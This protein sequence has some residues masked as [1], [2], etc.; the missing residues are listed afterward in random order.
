[1]ILKT[2]ISLQL[3]VTAWTATVP[4]T[5]VPGIFNFT[6][7]IDM[8]INI[9]S[10]ASPS[11][12]MSGSRSEQAC[13]LT[14][15]AECFSTSAPR[16]YTTVIHIYRQ[17]T[18]MS[19]C[20]V[21]DDFER[22]T[23]PYKSKCT[24]SDTI[25]FDIF[26]G[27]IQYLCT[28]QGYNDYLSFVPC[29]SNA[30]VTSEIN[31]CVANFPSPLRLDDL[32][33]LPDNYTSCVMQ[34][35]SGYCDGTSTN[36]LRQ[37]LRTILFPL[38]IATCQNRS[39]AADNAASSVMV[40]DSS[41]TVTA[42][43]DIQP[44]LLLESASVLEPVDA[45]VETYAPDVAELTKFQIYEE[46]SSSTYPIRLDESVTVAPQLLQE[47]SETLAPQMLQ[48]ESVTIAPQILQ[49]ESVTIAPQI[50]LD[51]SVSIAPQIL[52]KESVTVPP[53]IPQEE[54]VTTAPQILLDES[55][56]IAPQ[57][58]LDESV[59]IASQTMQEES[60][61]RESQLPSQDGTTITSNVTTPLTYE[62]STAELDTQARQ[63]NSSTLV[64]GIV[65]SKMSSEGSSKVVLGIYPSSLEISTTM[66]YITPH[67]SIRD[68][69]VR[70]TDVSTLFESTEAVTGDVTE[71]LAKGY[72]IQPTIAEMRHRSSGEHET[73]T[74]TT[75]G[76]K[77]GVLSTIVT[78]SAT[79]RLSSQELPT[80]V[81][82]DSATTTLS[83]QELP[84]NVQADSVTATS[85]LESSTDAG[86]AASREFSTAAFD[87]ANT[88]TSS[89]QEFSKPTT[90]ILKLTFSR[91][92][93]LTTE[94]DK[95]SPKS[96]DGLSATI[97]GVT[98]VQELLG[99]FST[100]PLEVRAVQESQ[101]STAA[102]SQGS[103]EI[104]SA[105]PPLV[106][107]IEASSGDFSITPIKAT[108]VQTSTEELSTVPLEIPTVV[109]V[110][111][112]EFSTA[113]VGVT[114]SQMSSENLLTELPYVITP[115]ELHDGFSTVPLHFSTSQVLSEEPPTTVVNG[116][117]LSLAVEDVTLSA[118]VPHATAIQSTL[119]VVS[120]PNSGTFGISPASLSTSALEIHV[121]EISPEQFLTVAPE[122][123]TTKMSVAEIQTQAADETVTE[124]L[125]S[126][127]TTASPDIERLRYSSREFVTES[128]TV[129]ATQIPSG[130]FSTV[131]P[132]IGPPKVV[133]L[134]RRSSTVAAD[135]PSDGLPNFAPGTSV[136]LISAEILPTI[137][138][139]VTTVEASTTATL[140]I[141]TD[142]SS[143]TTET[144][145]VSL[146]STT[147]KAETPIINLYVPSTSTEIK[148]NSN[149][150]TTISSTKVS[151]TGQELSTGI[152]AEVTT[153][154]QEYTSSADAV[155][156][157][158]VD[159]TTIHPS[160]WAL[161][162]TAIQNSSTE[163]A[164]LLEGFS[165]VARSIATSSISLEA[166][167]IASQQ[168]QITPTS[169]DV[170]S[171]A[172]VDVKIIQTSPQETTT[173]ASVT[174]AITTTSAAGSIAT[175]STPLKAPIATQL[176]ISPTS[177]DVMSTAAADATITQTFSQE[178]TTTA[179]VA[180]APTTTASSRSTTPR[181]FQT[182]PL[183]CYDCHSGAPG[184]WQNVNC[185]PNG[186]IQSWAATPNLCHG[187]CVS[188]VTKYPAGDVFRACSK[189]YYFPTAPPRDGCITHNQDL[190]CFCST[191]FCNT[192]D[193]VKEQQD[194]VKGTST[195]V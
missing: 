84:K 37:A 103:F 122:I 156:A 143:S 14:E 99:E 49:E 44:S 107:P 30:E 140:S 43:L 12:N 3:F 20:G 86:K 102:S 159:G 137:A 93:L 29:I 168:L 147:N 142:V 16:F 141:A 148:T 59:T 15:I 61:I 75:D 41:A 158:V 39:S 178:T 47:E 183:N 89:Q 46:G 28:E 153:L 10:P 9:S 173:T 164:A 6:S 55:V 13:Q 144:P 23:V 154:T 27:L 180:T 157:I 123:K 52:Q 191:D 32:C 4:T 96:V 31:T 185:P 51:E 135:I 116:V 2:C 92:K 114:T 186:L 63:Q 45:S 163:H 117:A 189:N 127:F 161:A 133:S 155:S 119:G 136:T 174:T 66:S 111:Q 74:R 57:I 109:K 90:D 7:L 54:S 11:S 73:S 160:L 72:F 124:T 192:R 162:T 5:T 181:D 87:A 26:T 175:S 167:P 108:T 24:S 21:A 85:S 40:S 78:D 129:V 187:P 79:T 165:T 118:I 100:T 106:T 77:T 95:V 110:L 104:V 112:R 80:I 50:L 53:Q 42:G 150:D 65:K 38:K 172:T 8:V 177:V 138:P 83:S 125:E 34:A 19:I 60:V 188:V 139:D 115:K 25:A 82:A 169:A 81:Q 134:Q 69:A 195:N 132:D 64:P 120:L 36:M 91:A 17:D 18:R 190:L 194:Y 176:Q 146:I 184:S 126:R 182:S 113:P 88:I 35:T 149:D 171:T 121:S 62:Y 151:T 56:T 130:Q 101:I 70:T 145:T 33:T 58:S 166:S 131:V 152:A 193:M 105:I 68:A 48:E 97:L 71:V 1:M 76:E 94:T 22:C 98:G 179:P 170:L 67:L 128:L